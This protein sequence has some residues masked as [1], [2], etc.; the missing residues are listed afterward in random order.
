MEG[1]SLLSVIGGLGRSEYWCRSTSSKA[2][3]PHGS[4]LHQRYSNNDWE[5][6]SEGPS[7]HLS[8]SSRKGGTNRPSQHTPLFVLSLPCRIDPFQQAHKCQERFEVKDPREE[9]LQNMA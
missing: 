6:C 1:C 8:F 2:S 9:A 3:D 4:L 5:R 7:L